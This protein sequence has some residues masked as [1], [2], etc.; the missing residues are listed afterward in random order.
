MKKNANF[1]C[2]LKFIVTTQT[3]HISKPIPIL[4]IWIALGLTGIAL[5]LILNHFSLNFSYDVAVKNMPVPK[6]V[7]G[8][9]FAG[10]LYWLLCFLIRKTIKIKQHRKYIWFI[11]IAVGAIMRLIMF[12][13]TPILEDDYQR[14]LWDGAVTANGLNPYR[15]APADFKNIGEASDK[16]NSI[17][18]L[19]SPTL[20]RINHPELR[21]IYPPVT[22]GLF[23]ISHLISPFSLNA[24]RGILLVADMATLTLLLLLLKFF[25]K[26]PIWVAMYWWNPLVLKELFNSAHM[27]AVLLPFLLGA[28]YLSLT[29]RYRLSSIALIFAAG[30][31][32]WPAAL[33]PILL[34]PTLNRPGLLLSALIPAALL[35][36]L[37][38]LPIIATTLD[39]NS[40]FVA[41]ATK[42]RNNGGL[43]SLISG[44][45]TLITSN[46]ELSNTLARG[47][48]VLVLLGIIAWLSIPLA[49]TP[50]EIF[51]R[52]AI[53]ISAIF[54]L[55]PA[56][57]PWYFVWVA[58]LL[59]FYR[60]NGL[61]A[62]TVL[63][64]LYY[65]AFALLAQGN[66]VIYQNY[67]IWLIWLPTW[68][69]LLFDYMNINNRLLLFSPASNNV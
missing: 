52:C 51:H 33:Y 21:T 55:S 25:T 14:Y 47:S 15:Y 69:L 19:T 16:L 38:I 42:W 29:K 6:L 10:I 66:Y 53:L 43:F 46:L 36:F 39:N 24:W 59:V 13:S 3:S 64:P 49:K 26:S 50:E 48:I 7:A 8:L 27:E 5:S 9:C 17:A 37:M 40:G 30:V 68:A 57:F 22:Q 23:A 18:A 4:L 45:W 12:S 32:I 20:S 35:G 60:S 65:T 54:L 44:V 2:R 56:Q 58:P 28:I 11:I 41:Y 62:L 61:I 34:R 67:I 31:K 1:S 63:M